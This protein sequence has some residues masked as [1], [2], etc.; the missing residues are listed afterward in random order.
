ME[1]KMDHVNQ[2]LPLSQTIPLGLQHVLAMY[3]GA[4]V[5][6]LIVGGAMK[7]TQAQLGYLVAADLFTCGIATLIQVIGIGKFAGIRLP[8]VLGCTFTAVGPMCIIGAGGGMSAIYGSIIA[9]GIF[10]LIFS[11][12]F[13]KLLRF[14]PAVV[15]GSVVTIIGLSLIPVAVN[16]AA[17]GFGSPDFGNPRNLALALFVLLVIIAVNKYCKGF[18]Q[19][20]SVL[21]GIVAGTA[22]A[23][24]MGMVDFSGVASAD[25]VRVVTPF[26]FG[27]PTFYAPGILLMCLV[28]IVSMIE[29]TGVFLATGKIVEKEVKGDDIVRGLRAE[30]LAQILGGIFNAFPYTTF[31]QNV[32]LIALT[33]VRSRYV[34]YAAGGILMGLG[35]FPKFAALATIIPAAV[36]GGAMIAMFGMVAISGMRTLSTVDMSKTNNMLVAACSISIG[37]GVVVVPGAVAKMPDMI[38]LLL[39]SG[40]VTGSFTAVFLNLFLNFKEVM[41]RTNEEALESVAIT[42]EHAI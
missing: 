34:L 14:F 39:E 10:A 35:M 21:V 25:M 20:I 38:R 29:S 40:I 6:P 24:A 33:G 23:A 32:G 36:I 19:A 3:A 17:G 2:K 30:G 5:V 22:V 28:A 9:S 37:L 15:T 18:M 16:N 1:A 41:S 27:M 11:Y 31:S 26:Y 42:D 7:M 8:L 4:V 12:F 13:G